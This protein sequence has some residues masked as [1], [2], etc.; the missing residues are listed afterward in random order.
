MKAILKK[1]RRYIE[2]GRNLDTNP[3]I[4]EAVKKIDEEIKKKPYR[5]DV[6]N[7]L[8]KYLEE[9][10]T[11][12]LEIGVRNPSENFSKIKAFKKYSVDPG[13][14]YKK[15]PVDFPFTS[16]VFFNKLKS[17]KIL[18]KDIK[19]DVIFIDGLH[20]ADQVD[21][22]IK[23]ALDYIKPEGFIV[24]HDCNPPSE[25]NARED[26]YARMH[27]LMGSWNG[28]TWKAFFKFRQNPE[29]FSCCVDSDWGIGIL[30]KSKDIGNSTLIKNPF[31]EFRVL[32]ENRKESLNLVSFDE[33][34]STLK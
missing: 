25:Y 7:F 6:I 16:D 31:Y 15:N 21:R 8:L 27:S 23:N 19:F 30:S 29:V 5:Y 17:G 32:D 28:T 14:E 4:V 10:N 24:L 1:Y 11:Q 18:K 33:L 20:L 9:K 3:T 13:I 26:Y 34:K 22:D 12:Y 2:L